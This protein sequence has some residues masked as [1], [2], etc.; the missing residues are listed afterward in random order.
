M[1]TQCKLS[2]LVN[3]QYYLVLCPVSSRLVTV[4]QRASPFN[5]T[6]IQVYTPTSSY[7]DGQGDEFYMELQ[8]LDDQTPTQDSLIVQGDWDWG[9]ICGHFCNLETNDRR[10]KLLDFAIYNNFV[11]TNTVGNN[12]PSNRWTWHSPDGTYHNQIDYI[13]VQK[14]LY[15]G[16]KTARTR[17]FPV[18][19]V[20]SDNQIVMMTFLKRLKK[21]SKSTQPR[22]RFDLRKLIEPTALS[23]F[24]AWVTPEILDFCDQRRDLEKKRGKPEGAIDFREI[25]TKIRT[26]MN[27]AKETWIQGQCQEEKHASERVTARKHTS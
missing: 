8:S 4:R 15:S 22:I 6:I 5:I 9:E 17:S 18:A 2:L 16:M 21:S 14:R 24:Q 20:G 11:L 26:A 23:V 19:D 7:D 27:M 3:L 1:W 10:L 25:K 13:L 12:K